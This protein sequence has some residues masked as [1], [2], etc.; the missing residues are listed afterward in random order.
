LSDL[1]TPHPLRAGIDAR[2]H[3]WL[4]RHSFQLKSAKPRYVLEAHRLWRPDTA[5]VVRDNL[6]ARRFHQKQARR[7][8]LRLIANFLLEGSLNTWASKTSPL[9]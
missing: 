6:F 5:F 7:T 3:S 4:I 9:R 1:K 2:D 8:R